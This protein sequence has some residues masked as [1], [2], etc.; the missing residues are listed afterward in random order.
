MDDYRTRA[1][2][3]ALIAVVEANLPVPMRDPDGRTVISCPTRVQARLAAGYTIDT[4]K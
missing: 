1:E 2:Y 3:D 4:E